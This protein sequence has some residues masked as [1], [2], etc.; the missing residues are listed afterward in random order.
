MSANLYF[1]ELMAKA[2]QEELLDMARPRVVPV[3]VPLGRRGRLWGAR[4]RLARWLIRVGLRLK[5][6]GAVPVCPLSQGPDGPPAIDPVWGC[7]CPRRGDFAA[8]PP[9]SGG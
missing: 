6:R 9:M 7:A 3:S 8:C 4:Q 1:L 5:S 2:R